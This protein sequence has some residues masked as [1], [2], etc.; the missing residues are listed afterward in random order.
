MTQLIPVDHIVSNPNN[1]RKDLG[2]LTDLTASV[3]QNGILQNLS[4][5]P[6]GDHVRN[7]STG[8][9]DGKTYM[10]VIGHR[11][12][13]AAREAGLTEV[14]CEIMQMSEADQMTTMLTENMQRNNLTKFEETSG[15]QQAL[16]L[17]LTESEVASKVGLSKATVI[18]HRKA[19]K[20][21]AD[22]VKRAYAHGATIDQLIQLAKI[23]DENDKEKCAKSFGSYN[24]DYEIDYALKKQEWKPKKEAIIKILKEELGAKPGKRRW[25]EGKEICSD[26]NIKLPKSKGK[27]FY[28][29]GEVGTVYLYS[30][31][32]KSQSSS[33][34]S[35]VSK[36]D[37]EREKERVSKMDEAFKIAAD[38][39]IKFCK[40][41]FNRSNIQ[42]SNIMM[43]RILNR[44]IHQSLP[45]ENIFAEIVGNEGQYD[46][47]TDDAIASKP[48]NNLMIAMLFSTYDINSVMICT[49]LYNGYT[50]RKDDGDTEM[51]A[52]LCEFGYQMSDVEK[53]MLD[54]TWDLFD[55]HAAG[56]NNNEV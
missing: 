50:Y 30:G 49:S 1:P 55:V 29:A 9:T 43:R 19:M 6:I 12:L 42:V 5:V 32:E 35:K 25:G 7:V 17:G 33:H 52:M 3:R 24:F 4:V 27:Y 26:E 14:P 18:K 36:K 45:D 48:V 56:R 20:V 13:A 28:F 54:G 34:Q 44:S 39:R 21:G 8:E 11:R 40:E 22:M 15:I 46:G 16:N 37:V 23:D 41:Y 10:V 38:L 51:Y 31:E 2:D 47:R 53:E